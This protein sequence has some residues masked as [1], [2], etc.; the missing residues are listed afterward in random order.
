MPVGGR[1]SKAI[2]ENTKESVECF[3][4]TMFARMRLLSFEE[5]VLGL[6]T[7]NGSTVVDC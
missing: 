3:R 5:S 2:D 4:T 6:S 1:A 7:D